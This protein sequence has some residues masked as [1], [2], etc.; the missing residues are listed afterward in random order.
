M[1]ESFLPSV[2]PTQAYALYIH[3]PFCASKCPYCDFNS[4]VRKSYDEKA[5][6]D[7]IIA[8]IN[9][10]FITFSPKE[11]SSIFFGGGTPSL[12]A[13]ESVEAILLAIDRAYPLST[14]PEITL[15]AN[16][17]SVENAKL[18]GFRKAGVNRLS[19]GVQSF[20]QKRLAFLG[21]KHSVIE[22][23]QAL[24]L[25]YKTFGRVSFD[26][27]YATPQQDLKAWEAEL[28]SALS[29]YDPD[30]LSLYQLTIEPNTVFQERVA[31][32]DFMVP[33]DDLAARF[34]QLTA[35]IVADKG[36][37][38]YEVSNYARLGQECL[39][40]L[41]YWCYQPYIGIGP[42]A[43]GRPGIDGQTF[44]TTQTKVPEK[45]LKAEQGKRYLEY[46][47]LTHE[48]QQRESLIMGLR[49]TRGVVWPYTE[50]NRVH[51]LVNHK[52]LML[53]NQNQKILLKPTDKGLLM[54]EGMLN[55]LLN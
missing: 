28:T 45:W 15:E 23:R 35:D 14:I 55:Y 8:E 51:Q 37:K 9:Q 39:H 34:Y 6:T 20:D 46:H 10:A 3:W 4:H 7:A 44:A 12:M 29:I 17:G 22:A 31:R 24:E 32:G 50:M 13:V 19:I 41:S 54:V 36:L 38:A 53:D 18:K 1:P 48:Q 25:A 42:G 27:I 16:P 52:L 40:N 5:W 49:S 21:R 47:A 2:A 11:I 26:L 33:N 43:H 30:H